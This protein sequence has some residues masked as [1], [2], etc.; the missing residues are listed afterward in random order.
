MLSE[1]AVSLGPLWGLLG[2]DMSSHVLPSWSQGSQ[3]DPCMLCQGP[4]MLCVT[5]WENRPSTTHLGIQG[6][7]TEQPV[8][9]LRV[10]MGDAAHALIPQIAYPSASYVE[11]GRVGM[12]EVVA[13]EMWYLTPPHTSTPILLNKKHKHK[14]SCGSLHGDS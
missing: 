7:S 3:N 11:G 13:F 8:W 5:L 2:L 4:N 12:D 6:V 10:S 1:P 14:L 9:L